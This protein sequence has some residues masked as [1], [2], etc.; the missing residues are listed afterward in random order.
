MAT[1]HKEGGHWKL[2]S[3]FDI[4]SLHYRIIYLTKQVQNEKKRETHN[5]AKRFYVIWIIF[6]LSGLSNCIN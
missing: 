1:M 4:T 6:S 5:V 3:N 2:Y